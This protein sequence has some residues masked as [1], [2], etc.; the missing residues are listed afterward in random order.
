[1]SHIRTS[2]S[3]QPRVTIII[4]CYNGELYIQEAIQSILNQTYTNYEIILIDDGSTDKTRACIA[5]YEQQLRY[6]YQD[7]QGVARARNHGLE[8]ARGELIAF[9]DAD[10][11]FLPKKLEAQVAVFEAHSELGMVHSGWHCVDQNGDFLRTVEPWHQVPELDLESWLLWKPVLPSAMMFRCDW[12]HS[13]GG[14]DPRFP[15][16]EDTELVLRLAVMGCQ[17]SWLPEVTVCYRQ[18]PQSA[19]YQG[20]PQA[21]SLVA[22]IDNFFARGDLPKRIAGMEKSVRYSTLVWIAWYL[23]ERG[24]S[25]EMIKVLKDSCQY[26]SLSPL[27]FLVDWIERFAQF[28]SDAAEELDVNALTQLQEW[29]QFTQWLVNRT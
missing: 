24:H 17:A 18:H 4:P 10:D 29:E 6:V 12:L 11:Y 20:L 15:P 1:M 19:M 13:V 26:R 5:P 27:E 3:S 14:F 22:V 16:A 23:Y 28:S 25:A 7:N 21:R 2:F 8:L 9:L